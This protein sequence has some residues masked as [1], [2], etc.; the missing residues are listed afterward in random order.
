MSKFE[1]GKTY[2]SRSI[3]DHN[4]IFTM[5]VVS[6]TAKTIKIVDMHDA[7]S[8]KTLRVA[9]YEGDETV[10]PLGTYSMCVVMRANREVA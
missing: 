5:Q 7:T 8:I 9:M 4:C 2:Q 1:S 10:K 3:G 6:R